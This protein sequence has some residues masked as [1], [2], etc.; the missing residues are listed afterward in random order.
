MTELTATGDPHAAPRPPG[1]ATPGHAGAGPAPDAA[2]A[3]PGGALRE[4]DAPA[5]TPDGAPAR[6]SDG[7]P[8][9]G[10]DGAGRSLRVPAGR[11]GE[12]HHRAVGHDVEALAAPFRPLVR[13]AV[14]EVREAAWGLGP[15]A[16][17][18]A[19]AVAAGAGA[20]LTARLARLTARTM[21]VELHRARREGRLGGATARER[22][23]DFVRQMSAPDELTRLFTAYPVLARLV[24]QAAEQTTA[25]H[26]ELLRRL[27]A[28]R[29]A[30]AD[31]LLGHDPGPLA[32]VACG[33][34]DRHRG[35][36]SVSRL[37]F[38][39][40]RSVVYK[41]RPLDLH[42]HFTELLGWL[43]DRVPHLDLSAAGCLTRD[44]YGWMEYI[45]HTPCADAAE[46]DG[47]YRRQGALLALLFA[48][49]ATDI[50]HENLIAAGDQPVLVDIETLFQPVFAPVAATGACPA[51]AVLAAS[52]ERTALLPRMVFG[53]HGALDVSG[54]GGDKDTLF[55]R[56]AVAWAD[57][58]TDRMRLV[59]R[60]ALFPGGANRPRLGGRAA[61]P[62]HHTAS[63]LGGFRAAYGA[64]SAHRGDLLG[65]GGLLRRFAG[66]QTR[67]LL[68]NTQ[69]Y[70]TLL[71]ESTHPSV[72]HD[73]AA[74]EEL[75][76]GLRDDPLPP[77]LAALA[78]PERADLWSDDVP[79]FHCRPDATD[80]HA[81]GG[82]RLPGALDGSGLARAEAKIAALGEVDRQTQE[83]LIDA[84]LAGRNA[85]V[86][87]RS[88]PAAPR[89]PPA[90]EA[91]PR[92]FLAAARALA[93]TLV[94]RAARDATRANWLGIEAL[95]ERYWKVMPM[96]A[97]LATGYSGVAL[98]L[99]ELGGLTGADRYRDLAAR[100][101][102]P[103]PALVARFAAD[104]EWARA[105]GCGAFAGV[106]GIGYA[107][108]R[109]A[110]LLDDSAL[111][112]ALPDAVT[113]TAR[114]ADPGGPLAL[115]DGL[116]GGVA[117]LLAVHA[118][119]GS[120]AARDTA[121]R[122]G[123]DLAARLRAAPADAGPEGFL[124]GADGIAWSLL[125]LAE[126]CRDP[127]AAELGRALARRTSA[128][129][130]SAPAAGDDAG[131]C[132]GLA[133]RLAL[134]SHPLL[135]DR[136]RTAVDAALAALRDAEPLHDSTPCHGETGVLA[137]LSAASG[138]HPGAR[139]L[140]ERRC[141]LLLGALDH[142]GPRCG[143]PG[144]VPTPGVLTGLAGIGHALLHHGF[145]ARVPPLP[146]LGT[147][148]RPAPP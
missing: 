99:A 30:L 35:G 133:G 54:M 49:D 137:G 23:V 117:A 37:R 43:N 4:P 100:A 75:F 74:R 45:A 6:T 24:G 79:L 8:A 70:A 42:A 72:L 31:T 19:D 52:V 38:A 60:P 144:G 90:E 97:G 11:P 134:W 80:V 55:P 121:A 143:T 3:A 112:D 39:D 18:D 142:E 125:R 34:G 146:L 85:P 51:A 29:A 12:A 77:P 138:Y 17:A 20:E 9:Q 101:V 66:D 120:A 86:E 28:D 115:H 127:A 32:V 109:L 61:D 147:T 13:A 53:E 22:F 64:L 118:E 83:W 113:A 128:A 111:R 62:A 71:D 59:R 114:A 44:G 68:R 145:P 16:R 123:A 148:T 10:L 88:R 76:D 2:D 108:A 116:A 132:S 46:L 106:G 67:V 135:A 131:W 65:P 110:T 102:R 40:G 82:H 33:L 140:L 141:Q 41:P 47:F 63:V 14:A 122:L 107:M 96:G 27:A 69:V 5:R 36:R 81:S 130:G 26:A 57:A 103:L 1:H 50:H 73:A 7:A 98:F 91:E 21:V 105:A 92:R 93:D 94:A 78:G 104:P 124:F 56:D 139:V 25:A 89:R 126:T 119:T 84:T 87:H 95:D 48:L 136:H 129:A 15:T 58:G